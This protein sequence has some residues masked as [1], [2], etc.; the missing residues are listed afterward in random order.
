MV[1]PAK[2]LGLALLAL[3]LLDLTSTSCLDSFDPEVGPLQSSPCSNDDSDPSLDVSFRND[4]TP[5]ILDTEPLGCLQCHA[6]DAPTPLGFEVSGL[7]LSTV[8]LAKAGGSD[9]D[10]TV[11]PN[12]PCES[13]LYQKVISGP[14][15]GARMPLGGP[16]YLSDELLQLVHDWISE[17]AKDN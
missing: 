5:R 11:I 7:D 15:F 4:I 13:I 14:P 2:R 8:A 1:I 9:G 12:Q 6:P 16:P 10:A 17:G 3:T